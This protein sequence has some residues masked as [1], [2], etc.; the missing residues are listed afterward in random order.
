M[1]AVGKIISDS[2]VVFFSYLYSLPKYLHTCACNTVNF[3][4]VGTLR[5]PWPC[6]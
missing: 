5:T 3:S 4:S 1:L 2:C 6:F